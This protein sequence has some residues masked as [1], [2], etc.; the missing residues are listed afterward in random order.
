MSTQIQLLPS[1]TSQGNSCNS[2]IINLLFYS[3]LVNKYTLLNKVVQVFNL[4]CADAINI[5]QWGCWTVY[6][7]LLLYQQFW[8]LLDLLYIW[9]VTAHRTGINK[10]IVILEFG[11][12]VL[13][14]LV[15][16]LFGSRFNPGL[17]SFI[18]YFFSLKKCIV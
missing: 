4:L 2:G 15:W 10:E 9:S 13:A 16:T 3:Y 18:N 8:L 14:A 1:A 5:W 6:Q 12:H 11:K 7:N 17:H